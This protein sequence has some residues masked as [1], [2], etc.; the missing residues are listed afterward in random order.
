MSNSLNVCIIYTREKYQE[1]PKIIEDCLFSN[2]L[3][4][5]IHKLTKETL[6]IF[7]IQDIQNQIRLPQ[8]SGHTCRS[9]FKICLILDL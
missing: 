8:K 9:L 7:I 6:I 4:L 5:Y 1:N 3:F 2:P